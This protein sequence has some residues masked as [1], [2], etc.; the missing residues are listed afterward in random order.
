MEDNFIYYGIVLLAIIIGVLVIKKIASCLI[1]I[2]V[3][4][5]LLA[6]LAFIYYCFFYT[7]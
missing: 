7:G 6:L 2:V 5:V 4:L 3:F 1:R